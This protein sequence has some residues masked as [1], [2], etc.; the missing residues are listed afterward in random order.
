MQAIIVHAGAWDIPDDRIQTHKEACL[1]ALLNG[2]NILN[3]GGGAEDA[4][5]EAIKAFESDYKIWA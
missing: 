2:W 5:E 3:T 1:K 4:V